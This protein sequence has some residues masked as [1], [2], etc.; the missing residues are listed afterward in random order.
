MS[1]RILIGRSLKQA[2][3]LV[4]QIARRDIT[5][6]YQPLLEIERIAP[7]A[8]FEQ[9]LDQAQA[10]IVT[11]GNAV[12]QLAQFTR[13]R[14]MKLL[15]VGDGTAR[16]ARDQGFVDVASAQGD[17]LALLELCRKRL[18]P[19][20]GRIL[21]LRGREVAQDLEPLLTA[22]GYTVDALVAYAT[23]A[24]QK[25]RPRVEQQ[26]RQVSLE[27]C[28][29]F[30]PRGAA[31]F[32]SLVRQAGF[33][34]ACAGMTLIAFSPAVAQAAAEDMVWR[35][36]LVAEKPTIPALLATLEQWRDGKFAE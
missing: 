27:A 13:K 2:G 3:P 23:E 7:P 5:G 25:F 1:R 36:K 11:S 28:V 19:Q 31:N 12:G 15:A 14:F 34:Y 24:V 9:R 6:V 32:V 8:D 10:V 29:L 16:L 35:L 26:L 4:E 30:S 33:D 22:N 18:D 21:Y 20:Q 17:A